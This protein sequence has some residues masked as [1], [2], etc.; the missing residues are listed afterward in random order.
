MFGLGGRK[1]YNGAIDTKLNN[2]YQISTE[3]NP[4]FPAALAYLDIIDHAWNGKMTEDEGA[5]YIATLYYCGLVRHGLR[6]E[7][8]GLRP[9][10]IRVADF[11]VRKGMIAEGRW[12]KFEKAIEDADAGVDH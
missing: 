9:R 6:D 7:A 3:G 11:G 4:N 5:L 8:Q 10:I 2:E 1:K 12:R